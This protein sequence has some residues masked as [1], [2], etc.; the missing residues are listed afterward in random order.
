MTLS[1]TSRDSGNTVDTLYIHTRMAQ[2]N[3]FRGRSRQSPYNIHGSESW[4]ERQKDAELKR[5]QDGELRND[6]YNVGVIGEGRSNTFDSP[7]EKGRREKKFGN[8]ARLYVGN[9]PRSITEDELRKLFEPYGETDQVYVEK[10]KNFG[11]VRMVSLIYSIYNQTC[12]PN[13]N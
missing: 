2:K 6:S 8:R 4:R 5:E 13:L 1:H 3:G 10:E 12:H 9:L 7:N 11:F